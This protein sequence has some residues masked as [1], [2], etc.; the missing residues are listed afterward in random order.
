MGGSEYE[1][2]GLAEGF[3]EHRPVFRFFLTRVAGQTEDNSLP[4]RLKS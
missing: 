2:Y 3:A 1:A 4:L